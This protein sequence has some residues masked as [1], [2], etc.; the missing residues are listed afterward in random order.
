MRPTD[1]CLTAIAKAL[2]T[3]IA[4]GLAALGALAGGPSR[5]AGNARGGC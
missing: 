1:R 5:G 3:A 4:L 2:T